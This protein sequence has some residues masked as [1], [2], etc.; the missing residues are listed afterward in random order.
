MFYHNVGFHVAPFMA[1]QQQQ[2]CSINDQ[3]Y[4]MLCFCFSF[5]NLM[6]QH[7]PRAVYIMMPCT[8]PEYGNQFAHF[9]QLK[10]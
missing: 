2:H 9:T 6:Q 3:K 7:L 10:S 1:S 4:P 5:V 8:Q